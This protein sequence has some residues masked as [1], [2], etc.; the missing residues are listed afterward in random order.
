[1]KRLLWTVALLTAFVFTMDA[2]NNY[3]RLWSK[4]QKAEKEGKPQTAAGYLRELE[5]QTIK[6]G[7]ELE[8]LVVSEN[9]YEDLRK[10]NW[11]EANAYYSTYATLNRR[12]LSDSLDAYVVKYKDHPRV[13]MLLY[14]Q[15][16]NHKEAVDRRSR[17]VV[18]GEDYLAV[19]REAVFLLEPAHGLLGLAAVDAVDRA[20]VV[21]PVFEP[22]LDLRHG[23]AGGA[24]LI[25]IR[26]GSLGQGDDEDVDG[27]DHREGQDKFSSLRAH[28]EIPPKAFL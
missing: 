20:A 4:V 26:R 11:K 23:R 13:M 1:M 18:R 27:E 17:S 25:Q 7:D 19:R 6:A 12:V 5:A 2:Q 14:K 9:L 22:A 8:Q 3:S 16:Q 24:P 15:L 21:A 28:I 10:Y